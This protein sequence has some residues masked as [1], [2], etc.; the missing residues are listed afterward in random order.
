MRF[1]NEKVINL[2]QWKLF[3]K[4][5]NSQDCLHSPASYNKMKEKKENDKT[6]ITLLY[7]MSF[8]TTQQQG[9]ILNATLK[10]KSPFVKCQLHF[11]SQ[12]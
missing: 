12:T 8:R 4:T 7:R 10:A 6:K 5:Q 9:V 11:L 1:K 3:I 2:D